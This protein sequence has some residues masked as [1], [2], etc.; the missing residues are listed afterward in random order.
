MNKNI[1]NIFW[2]YKPYWKYGKLFVFLSL[3]F[4][5]LVVPASNLIN[6]YLPTKIIEYLGNNRPFKDIIVL[7]ITF[8]LLLMFQ[9]VYE[10]IF[11][12]FCKNKMLAKIEMQ[13]KRDIYE[14]AIKTDYK[15]I[16]NPEYYNSYTWA[17]SE[18]ANKAAE[19]QV[20]INR[21]SSSFITMVSMLAIIA[22]I[23][24]IA[25]V[26]MVA[27]VL[28]ENA[29]YIVTNFFDVKKDTE[30]IPYDRRLG[31]YHRVFYQREY[32]ADLKSTNLKKYIFQEYEKAKESK[33]GIIQKYAW[34]MIGW[35]FAG[36]FT[37]YVARTFIILNI[38]Y[39]IYT[40]N[41]AS[42]GLYVTMMLAVQRLN[43]TMNE[44]FYRVK[45]GNLLGMYV[46]KIRAFF[47]MKSEIEVE[48]LKQRTLPQGSYSVNFN[49][50]YFK[51]EN[52]K[53]A[54]SNFNLNIN[55]GE[56]IAIVG[57]NGA[58]K[59]TLVKLLLRLYDVTSGC[60]AINGVNIREYNIDEFRCKIGVAFQNS[61]VYALSFAK[62]IELY[63][64]VDEDKLQTIVDKLKLNKILD[65]SDAN[66]STELTKEFDENG[67]MLSGGEVQKIGI[68][69]LL[70][71]DFGLLLL[72]EPS[73]ALDPIAEYEMTKL[74]LDSSNRSTTIVVAHRLSTI[75][76]AD[77][78]ILVDGGEIKEIGTHD[79]LMA[80]KGKYYEMF[81]KQAENY[82]I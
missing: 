27:G 8:Q 74:I 13:L 37:F 69:R 11:N 62:N 53:F 28:V 31:Y 75:R 38:A 7:V 40:G 16:D 6:V 33:L 21:M 80:I 4:W 3:F 49:D 36:T 46:T 17:I 48:T 10:D 5:L 29:M 22:M 19:V 82:N 64:Q 77:R 30:I 51:Y 66:F 41:I 61:I 68:A 56:K 24:P 1:K 20:L 81:T 32:A 25:I 47:D 67:I 76:Y 18:Y 73:S 15:Y 35:A 45:D 57:E 55:P 2:L 71:G 72:D 59:S 63:N 44:L 65:K 23:S 70:T 79:E 58:G 78:I 50:V 14:R 12:M 54:V 9:P 43:D 60:I 26:V 34:K 52:S 39:G 42:V